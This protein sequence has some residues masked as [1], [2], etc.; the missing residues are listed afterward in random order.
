MAKFFSL[1]L[2][3]L[4]LFFLRIQ[5]Q[6]GTYFNSRLGFLFCFFVISHF[7]N[8]FIKNLFRFKSQ[9]QNRFLLFLSIYTFSFFFFLLIVVS[10]FC[11][12]RFYNS[13]YFNFSFLTTFFILNKP[14]TGL[15]V[16]FFYLYLIFVLLFLSFT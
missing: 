15:F 11:Y 7:E 16:I 10:F 4:E 14:F 9:Q 2:F 3:S 6:I 5:Q 8:K 1:K 13:C 12:F